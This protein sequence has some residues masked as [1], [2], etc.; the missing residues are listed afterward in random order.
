M[1]PESMQERGQSLHDEQ[2]RNGE[3]SPGREQERSHDGA[4]IAGQHLPRTVHHHRPQH[5]R[6]LCYITCGV[7]RPYDLSTYGLESCFEKEL[8]M[9]VGKCFPQVA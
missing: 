1:Q 6:Q 5:V 8:Q 9:L 4:G 2:N 7:Q 3:P